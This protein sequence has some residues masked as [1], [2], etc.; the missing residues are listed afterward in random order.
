VLPEELQL[1]VLRQNKKR[2]KDEAVGFFEVEQPSDNGSVKSILAVPS[3]AIQ[4]LTLVPTEEDAD[5]DS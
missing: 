5:S 2:K 4:K 3:S 1:S